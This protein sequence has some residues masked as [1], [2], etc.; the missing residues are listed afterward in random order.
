MDPEGK[1]KSSDSKSHT[2]PLLY[3]PTYRALVVPLACQKLYKPQVFSSWP[4]FSE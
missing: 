2:P 3:D 4:D 1:P